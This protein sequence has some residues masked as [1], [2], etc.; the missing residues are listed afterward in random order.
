ME[1]VNLTNAAKKILGLVVSKYYSKA[2]KFFSAKAK[3][4]S[5]IDDIESL[6]KI[7]PE[8]MILQ[9][10]TDAALEFYKEAID[11]TISLT[12]R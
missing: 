5:F 3:Y 7:T 12:L 4:R 8:D 9:Q 11:H 6:V 2:N 10:L 1:N